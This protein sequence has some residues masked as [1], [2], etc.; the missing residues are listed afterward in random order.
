MNINEWIN[1]YTQRLDRDTLKFILSGDKDINK[2]IGN[3]ILSQKIVNI[4][5]SNC[6]LTYIPEFVMQI[7]ENIKSLNLNK[8]KIRS[9]PNELMDFNLNKLEIFE[10]Y[11]NPVLLKDSIFQDSKDF[12]KNIFSTENRNYMTKNIKKYDK[13]ESST[14]RA[15][16]KYIFNLYNNLNIGNLEFK[17]DNTNNLI[18]LINIHKN[19]RFRNYDYINNNILHKFIVKSIFN[20]LFQL[21]L[22]PLNYNIK[23]IDI[24]DIYDLSK[25]LNNIFVNDE[26]RKKFM[27]LIENIFLSE[28]LFNDENAVRLLGKG[29]YNIAYEL[30]EEYNLYI[31][32]QL[33]NLKRSKLESYKEFLIST[34]LMYNVGSIL[35][36]FTDPICIFNL[37]KNET[38][39]Y[40]EFEIINKD[41]N[42]PKYLCEFDEK[43][44]FS[45]SQYIFDKKTSSAKRKTILNKSSSSD[46]E[47][48]YMT[49]N[50]EY[51]ISLN[52]YMKTLYNLSE[53]QINTKILNVILQ[54]IRAISIAYCKIGFYHG[55]GHSENIL[56]N[57]LDDSTFI[58]EMYFNPFV[59]YKY[60]KT[61][62]V[63][64]FIDYGMSNLYI[65]K[66]KKDSEENIIMHLSIQ[67]HDEM[68][69]PV[70]DIHRMYYSIINDVYRDLGSNK[71][72]KNKVLH[73]IKMI[74][75][76]LGGFF[77]ENKRVQYDTQLNFI[78]SLAKLDIRTTYNKRIYMF[79]D[80]DAFNYGYMPTYVNGRQRDKINNC[81]DIYNYFFMQYRNNMNKASINDDD[82]ELTLDV[83]DEF[84]DEFLENSKQFEEII[85]DVNKNK[86]QNVKFLEDMLKNKIN[87]QLIPND[88]YKKSINKLVNFNNEIYTFVNENLKSIFLTLDK[89]KIND[90]N[91]NDIT[92]SLEYLT[93][94]LSIY[95]NNLRKLCYYNTL[96]YYSNNLSLDM[97]YFDPTNIMTLLTNLLNYISSKTIPKNSNITMY[98]N[99]IRDFYQILKTSKF[100]PGKITKGPAP[101]VKQKYTTK[102]LNSKTIKE[103]KDIYND[104]QKMNQ[105]LVTK[106]LKRIGKPI[107]K[108]DKNDYI[109]AIIYISN[110]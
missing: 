25:N 109:R 75:I 104:L 13:F 89:S 21:S 35:P 81:F 96:N 29:S 57:T 48:Y 86:D 6:N 49:R 44:Y 68:A 7:I 64:S 10:I 105:A 22:N 41:P 106:L 3:Y 90:N 14:D 66:K 102:I 69:N 43:Y 100:N 4:D 79:D 31:I 12:L 26:L 71:Y 18:D 62:E 38:K 34:V 51:G 92:K 85:K 11:D 36:N 99:V 97:I 55:D 27:N 30:S 94:S 33:I 32:K 37:K 9:I 15:I 46:I 78:E 77:Y 8:N 82:T 76:Y 5:L 91:I 83:D 63:V 72:A 56:I 59:K 87:K 54:I 40:D 20:F 103:L 28:F 74:Y 58:Q 108:F 88:E 101:L 16:S 95:I 67:S 110:N 53:Q 47:N 84:M 19:I 52:K 24:D 60:H 73:V 61:K 42:V 2:S 45:N 65:N 39:V 93:K 17:N 50:V 70:V 80:Y 1:R 107:S 23:G 98:I